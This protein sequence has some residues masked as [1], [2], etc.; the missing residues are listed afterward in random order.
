M[1]AEVLGWPADQVQ[2]IRLAAPMHDLGKIGI[3]DAILQKPGKLTAEEFAV[4]KTHS[5]IG[6]RMLEGSESAILQMAHEI[7]LAHHERWD[8][9]GY[10]RGLAGME[11]PESARILAIVDV[12]DALTHR[13]VY[14]EAL[15]E[16]EA[17]KIMELDRGKHFDP[18]LFG[19]F[20]SLLPE[21][22]RI[23][24]QN[25]DDQAVGHGWSAS[26]VV[27]PPLPEILLPTPLA[28]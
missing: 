19:V 16:D 4:M 24:R 20:L 15:P 12:Y 25:P 28:P 22:R 18:F 23:A 5:V 17:M 2:N 7:A 1:F 21:I 14:H 27:V 10:P 6:A 13:R 8:G 26:V 11:I 3:P 9:S